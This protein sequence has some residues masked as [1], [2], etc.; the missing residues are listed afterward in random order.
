LDQ[1]LGGLSAR[2]RPVP[3]KLIGSGRVD[4]NL[5]ANIR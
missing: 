2:F 1:D 4:G 5:I 3:H